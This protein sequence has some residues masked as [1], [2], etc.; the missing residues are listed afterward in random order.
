MIATTQKQQLP[1]I[2]GVERW[3]ITFGPSVEPVGDLPPPA[4]TGMHR[5]ARLD[6]FERKT[7]VMP[8]YAAVPITEERLRALPRRGMYELVDT[9]QVRGTGLYVVAVCRCGRCNDST[10]KIKGS[11]WIYERDEHGEPKRVRGCR[12]YGHVTGIARRQEF[13][14]RRREQRQLEK[15]ALG[16][17]TV[18]A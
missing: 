11:M 10:H 12:L 17:V 18:R 4:A 5:D 8:K 3:A 2:R 15:L 16:K 6:P 7:P 1:T 14:K 13:A 9:Y